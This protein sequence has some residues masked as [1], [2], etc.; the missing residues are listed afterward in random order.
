MRAVYATDLSEA[1]ETATSVREGE[2]VA[3]TL[4]AEAEFDP[5]TILVGAR[6]R[7]RI[8]RTGCGDP[9]G[10]PRI[11]RRRSPSSPGYAYASRCS[12]YW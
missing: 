9:V 10:G 11:A 2:T 4:A 7:S 5:T 12:L 8:R 3:E 1:I 6:G